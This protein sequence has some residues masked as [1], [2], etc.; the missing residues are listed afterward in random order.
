MRDL[1]TVNQSNGQLIE[2]GKVL[3]RIGDISYRDF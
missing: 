1:R 3:K 2:S